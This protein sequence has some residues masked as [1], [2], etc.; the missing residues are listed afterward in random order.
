[1]TPKE[2][3]QALIDGKTLT[4]ENGS[5]Y[6]K[7]DEDGN[8]AYSSTPLGPL[9][10]QHSLPVVGLKEY[11]VL[12]FK[13]LPS[14]CKFRFLPHTNHMKKTDIDFIKVSISK[15]SYGIFSPD[16]GIVHHVVDGFSDDSP[17]VRV[18]S[19]RG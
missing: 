8:V 18:D 5:L 2:V 11:N 1:M 19:G 16:Y 13:D 7:L 17:V 12:T 15:S 4:Y 14:N 9:Y 3:M 10:K 6:L